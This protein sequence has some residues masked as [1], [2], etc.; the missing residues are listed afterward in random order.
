METS[1]REALG[2]TKEEFDEM[3][4][5]GAMF[6]EQGN[7]EKAQVIFEGLVELDSKSPEAHSAL[8]AL[9]TRMEMDEEALNH[10][11]IAIELCELQIEAYVNRAEVRLRQVKDIEL[12]IEDL[13]QAIELDPDGD[14]PAANRARAM[15]MVIY[16]TLKTKNLVGEL[17]TVN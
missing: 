2:I 11:N 8:G 17:T 10:L 4:S 16:E 1:I 7:L 3:G 9:Y 5:I 6:Y 15:V 12:A 13:N 14:D